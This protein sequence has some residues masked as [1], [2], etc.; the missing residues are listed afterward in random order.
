[1][2]IECGDE[3]VFEVPV[4]DGRWRVKL[5][6]P[7]RFGRY[8]LVVGQSAGDISRFRVSR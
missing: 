7:L 6:R 3:I 2:K 5:P 4:R 1:M 8:T